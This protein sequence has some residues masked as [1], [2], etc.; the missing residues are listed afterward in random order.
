[1]NNAMES[2]IERASKGAVRIGTAVL[3]VYLTLSSSM[4]TP[5]FNVPTQSTVSSSSEMSWDVK[6]VVT[7]KNLSETMHLTGNSNDGVVL[8]TVQTSEEDNRISTRMRRMSSWKSREHGIYSYD[9]KQLHCKNGNLLAIYDNETI[10]GT[11]DRF[12]KYTRLRIT[13]AGFG[14]VRIKGVQSGMYV[15]MNK[16]G[17]LYPWSHP[18]DE[19]V[20]QERFLPTLY[21]VFSSD[22]HSGKRKWYI[23]LNANGQPRLGR[24]TK[25]R[26]AMAQFLLESANWDDTR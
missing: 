12:D 10:N 2:W 4:P 13:T 7:S 16:H 9:I 25:Y 5:T 24:K 14:R 15:C 6:T 18:K 8:S 26:H 21:A 11:L 3:L 17:R 1:M 23:G 19:C 22:V 20:F